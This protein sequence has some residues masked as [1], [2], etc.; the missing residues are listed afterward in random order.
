MKTRCPRGYLKSRGEQHPTPPRERLRGRHVAREDKILQGINSGSGPPWESVGPLH[1]RTRPPGK[2]QDLH[3]YKPDPWDGSRTPLCGVRATHGRVSGFWDKEYP[4][5][6]QDQAG[7]RIRHVFRPCRVRFCSP[8]RQR[9]DAATWPT[10]RD[11]S[12]RVEPDVR[13]LG[14]VTSAFIVDKLR[15]LSIPLAGDVSPQHLMSPDHS[16]G[17]RCA[18]SAFNEPCP[19]R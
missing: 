10:A 12:Q 19:L 9:P 17:R 14:R 13:P 1:I 15:R 2:V 7:V 4:D 8:L 11:V 5:L 6:N 18:A 16:T 3:G